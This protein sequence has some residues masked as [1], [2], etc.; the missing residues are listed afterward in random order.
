MNYIQNGQGS[1]KLIDLHLL[2]AL[3]FQK[4]YSDKKAEYRFRY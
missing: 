3:L 4:I 2:D 1:V